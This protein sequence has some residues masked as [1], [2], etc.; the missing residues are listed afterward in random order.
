LAA[1]VAVV[2]CH[3]P[4]L[5]FE[6]LWLVFQ[7]PLASYKDDEQKDLKR[8]GELARWQLRRLFSRPEPV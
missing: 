4:Y 7:E 3:L 6:L 8:I 1:F 2:L 5:P